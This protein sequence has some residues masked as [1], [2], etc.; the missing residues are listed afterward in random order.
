[1]PSVQTPHD[2]RSPSVVFAAN[3]AAFPNVPFCTGGCPRVAKKT[4]AG[5]YSLAI[6]EYELTSHIAIIAITTIFAIELALLL[7]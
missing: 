7:L 1:M 4:I 2:A 6:Y 3:S 5:D